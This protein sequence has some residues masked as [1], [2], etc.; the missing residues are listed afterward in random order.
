MDNLREVHGIDL[1]RAKGAYLETAP[2]RIWTEPDWVLEPKLDGTRESLQIGATESLLVGRNREGFLKGVDKA[3][4]FQVHQHPILSRISCPEL[5]GTLLDGELTMHF[6]QDGEYDENTKVR[7]REG[8]FVGFTVWQALFYQG[9]DLREAQDH[10]RRKYAARA[11]A[12]LDNAHIQLIQRYRATKDRLAE[13]WSSGMEGA[14]AKLS[15]GKLKP[16]Q[17]TASDWYKLKTQDTVD[18]FITGVTEGKSGG[19][20][21]KGV[22]PQYDGTAATFTVSLFWKKGGKQ[23]LV[24]VAKVKALPDEVVQNGFRNFRDF[25]NRVIEMRVSGWNGKAFRWARFLRFRDDKKPT[26]C[27]FHEQIACDSADKKA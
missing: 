16:G 24:E 2:E 14:I 1:P 15:T 10:V 27:W 13:I 6:T 3:G 20:G 25:K 26:E 18:A 17:R 11:I 8:I 12:Q 7:E 9:H 5:E 21:V 23:G 4:G 19:S 22:K